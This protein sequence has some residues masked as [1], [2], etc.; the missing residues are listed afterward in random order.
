MRF[1]S[2]CGRPLEE[3]DNELCAA[4]AN[5]NEKHEFKVRLTTV[6]WFLLIVAVLVMTILVFTTKNP[7]I[8]LWVSIPL[9]IF[10]CFLSLLEL[11]FY[12][13]GQ[14]KRIYISDS[15]YKFCCVGTVV[16]TILYI[17]WII[18]WL[19]FLYSIT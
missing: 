11:K 3:N 9:V 17:C 4:C 13:S 19:V 5:P 16:V 7:F 1:C 8:I 2:I 6:I 12:N 14:S 10:A 18:S 15:Y